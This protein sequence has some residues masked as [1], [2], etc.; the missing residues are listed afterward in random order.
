MAKRIL[1]ISERGQAIVLIALA[2][3]GMIAIVGLMTDGGVLFIEYARL[4]RGIDAA[5]VSAALS[6]RE[7]ATPQ[8][9]QDAAREFLQLNQSDV[10]DVAVDICQRD[11]NG[12]PSNPVQAAADPKLCTPAPRK[13]V[14]VT[15]TRHVSFG[16]LS[17]IGIYG[18]NLTATSVGEAAALDLVLVIDTSQS[19]SNETSGDPKLADPDDDPALCNADF[20]CEPLESVKNVATDFVN[21]SLYFPYDRVAIVSSTQQIENGTRDPFVVL[22]LSSNKTTVLD[23][24]G[25][26]R[27]FQPRP[28]DNPVGFS[29]TIVACRDI[30]SGV[31]VGMDCD[32][33]RQSGDFSTYPSSNLGGAL[34]Q[35]G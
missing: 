25:Q 20:T 8:E 7:S 33:C 19:M 16:F 12:V 11:E 21:T 31:Y 15:A 17:V 4:K 9:L 3:V 34:L 14:R 1:K 29:A 30:T 28:C 22:N 18:T 10:F 32:Y 24:I 2:I 6:F 13:L 35:A 5:A 26:L 23:A 27:V